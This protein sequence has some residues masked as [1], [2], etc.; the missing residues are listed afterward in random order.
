PNF[1]AWSSL[2]HKKRISVVHDV[3]FLFFPQYIQAKNLAY[4]Q[5]QLAKSLHRS[6]KVIAVSEA[7]KQDLIKH[8]QVPEEKL[9][10]VHNAVDH[11]VFQPSAKQHA[12]EVR[13]KFDIP[14]NYLLFVGNIDPRKN[15]LGL[16]KAYSRTHASHH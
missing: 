7:T 12:D 13:K 14:E 2:F 10:I 1:I 8:Y 15:L 6:D 3:A 9:A 11:A 5:K 4:L 16:L